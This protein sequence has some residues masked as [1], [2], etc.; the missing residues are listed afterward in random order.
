MD[1]KSIDF[2]QDL[3]FDYA[4]DKKNSDF[5]VKMMTENG[6]NYSLSP[7]YCYGLTNEYLLYMMNN[8]GEE[9]IRQLN[10]LYDIANSHESGLT[11]LERV[12]HEASKKHAQV[13]LNEFMSDVIKVQSTYQKSVS[14]YNYFNDF[15]YGEINNKGFIDYINKTIET[16]FQL[17]KNNYG[18]DVTYYTYLY[19]LQKIKLKKYAE[20]LFANES[21]F[22]TPERKLILT[23]PLYIKLKKKFIARL[24]NLERTYT[25]DDAKFFINILNDDI[26]RDNYLKLESHNYRKGASVDT[27][28]HNYTEHLVNNNSL[29]DFKK[30]LISQTQTSHESILVKFCTP[31]HAMA[32]SAVYDKD[33]KLWNYTFFDP[34]NGVIK[35]NNQDDFIGYLD[36]Y[37]KMNAQKYG[38]KLL[39]NN[40]YEIKTF[41]LKENNNFKGI[42]EI[43]RLSVN[44]I[45][46]TENAI[47]VDRKSSVIDR[48]NGVKIIYESFNP[49]HNL[50]KV[51]VTINEKSFYV[52]SNILDASDLQDKIINNS[53]TL[54]KLNCDCFVSD[55]KY[56]VYPLNER[57]NMEAFTVESID[58]VLE[59]EGEQLKNSQSDTDVNY[60][61]I[62]L[63]LVPLTNDESIPMIGIPKGHQDAIT[64]VANKHNII[65]GFRPVDIKSTSLINSG[66]YSSKGLSIKGKS[67][68]WGPHSGFIPI[69]QKYAKQS[70][71]IEFE[72]Y[73]N[74][75]QQSIEEHKAVAITLEITPER[76]NELI[77]YETI[78]PLKQ[79]SG[80][81]YSKTT[82]MVDGQEII[83]LL[84]KI[85]QGNNFLW[86]V[87]YQDGEQI[88]PFQ[89]IGDPKT[90]KAMTADYDLFS[91]IFPIS[92]LEDYIKVT[93]MPTWKEWKSGVIYD[94]L[95]EKQKRVYD[96]E[97]EYNKLEG[98]DNGIIN[99]KIKEIKNDINRQLGCADGFELVHH[100][101]DDAN[102]ASVLKDNFP[103]AFFLP[104]ALK[105]KNVL[106]GSTQSIDTYFPMNSDGAIIIRNVAELSDFQQ[107]LIN[108]GYRAPINQKWSEGENVNYFGPKRKISASL[109][110]AR[111]EIERKKSII[112]DNIDKNIEKKLGTAAVRLDTDFED[113][114]IDEMQHH[115]NSGLSGE[116]SESTKK[117]NDWSDPLIIYRKRFFQSNEPVPIINTEKYDYNVI[118]QMADDAAVVS[119][120]A[121]AFSKHP[122]KSMIIQ[123]DIASQQYHI[124]HGELERLN[125]GNIRWL[126]VGH[127][128]YEGDNKP[129]SL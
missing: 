74:Y 101:A 24:S 128:K 129:T 86:Q 90:G 110:I 2:N 1:N 72:K 97:V 81:E 125:T 12:K 32:V 87:Y 122:D 41:E 38:F 103:I 17:Y 115:N 99:K 121:N 92:Q 56:N 75:I 70:A 58:G 82:S 67:A 40:D 49:K 63:Q 37:V 25:I 36:L 105:G 118:I 79:L 113:V 11:L 53:E 83:F 7:G 44:D 39:K 5:F 47:L 88:K 91:I 93:E 21:F 52:Y 124:L 13:L 96:N 29:N 34:N 27:K 71:R 51:N 31:R 30:K 61:N 3:F 18:K 80:S 60:K 98:K 111:S 55:G 85:K 46:I 89:V 112:A 69:Q 84:K 78:S 45:K 109:M 20:A 9:Y 126:T 57:V 26:Q 22:E 23:D 15:E 16:N 95:T 77:G 59:R 65:I 66:T 10:L 54:S 119:A 100:G 104:D 94:D 35:F 28:R 50:V 120:V 48:V 127:G 4:N 33:S 117:I 64:R 114:Y 62:N 123:Y 42:K 108:Q 116:K 73:N 68:D 43:K 6:I 76:V 102:P 14:H 19:E 106:S 8:Q 107:L